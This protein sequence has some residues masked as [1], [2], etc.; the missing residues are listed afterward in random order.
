MSFFHDTDL[1]KKF[2]EKGYVV[3]DFFNEAEIRFFLDYWEKS[4]H[5][6]DKGTF[7]SIFSWDAD[8]N[9]EFSALVSAAAQPKVNEILPGWLAEGA[10]YTVKGPKGSEPTQFSLHQ[11]NNVVDEAHAP[12]L[13]LWVALVDTDTRNG[14]L[15]VLP[16]SHEKFKGAIRG[17]GMPSLFLNFDE[18]VESLVEHIQVKAGQA[19]IFAH[20]LF[21]GSPSNFTDEERIIIHAGLFAPGSTPLHYF[22][23]SDADGKEV[24]EILQVDRTYYYRRIAEFYKDAKSSP[25]TVIGTLSGSPKRPTREEVLAA[26]GMGKKTG[27]PAKA[28]SG[29]MMDRL[30]RMLQKR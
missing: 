22:K 20:S 30:K 5:S 8:R 21:H 18:E 17:T 9:S 10:T 15:C 26:Y 7:T 24:V 23:T 13:G 27:K 25:H 4:P 12:S 28:A 16:G 29:G 14:G 1:Q 11:D 3:I 6:F 2:D 19:C